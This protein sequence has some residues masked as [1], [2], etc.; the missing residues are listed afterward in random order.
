M[1][2]VLHHEAGKGFVAGDS[3]HGDLTGDIAMLEGSYAP[4]VFDAAHNSCVFLH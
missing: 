2:T 1:C 4:V 3:G